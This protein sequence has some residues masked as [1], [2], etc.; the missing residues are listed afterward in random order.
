V[1]RVL[2]IGGFG[3]LGAIARHLVDGWLGGVGRGEFPWATF[4]VNIAGSFALG[5]LVALTSS[6]VL[7]S[8]NWRFAIGVGFL[9]AFTTFSTFTYQ[10]IALAEGPAQGTALL[11]V[12][13]SVLLGLAAAYCGLQLG[14]LI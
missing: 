2:L 10:A 6:G 4:T 14:R 9:G 7:E 5:V 3:A 1:T 12:A 11:Y 8:A 13:G